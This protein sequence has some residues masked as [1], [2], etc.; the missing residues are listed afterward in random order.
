MFQLFAIIDMIYKNR[1]VFQ[2]LAVI[3]LENTLL[4]QFQYPQKDA[5]DQYFDMLESKVNTGS[6]FE[7]LLDI[8]R[9]ILNL[10]TRI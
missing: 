10:E 5:S 9:G 4:I 2:D 6:Q 3:F 8:S 1:E 7:K